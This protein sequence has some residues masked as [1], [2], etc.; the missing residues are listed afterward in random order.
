MPSRLFEG[1][2][3][4]A[5]LRR[6]EQLLSALSGVAWEA[7]PDSGTFLYVSDHA[8]RILGFP[9]GEWQQPG[10][11][12]AH[13][14]PDDRDTAVAARRTAMRARQ[15]HELDYRMVGASGA[16]AWLRDI[17][18][19]TVEPGG[20]VRLRGLIVDVTTQKR[21]ERALRRATEELVRAQ[22]LAQIRSFAHD[23][24]TGQLDGEPA[25]PASFDA[26]LRHVHPADAVHLRAHLESTFASD[27]SDFCAEYR[28]LPP[29]GPM[30]HVA[31]VGHVVR[32][33]QRRAVRVFGTTQDVTKQRADEAASREH[34]H[35]LESLD[36]V[37]RALQGATS[38][39]QAMDDVLDAMLTMFDCDR[40]WVVRRTAAAA[41]EWRVA[42]ERTRPEHPG[43]GPGHVFAPGADATLAAT[44]AA[45]GR[46]R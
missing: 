15:D 8:E 4:D 33:A 46:S 23:I 17:A 1:L 31:A 30:R 42:F 3:G 9:A 10:F 18:S 13:L 41:P 38:L 36:V 43:A 34:V 2:T 24:T 44:A 11:W 45:G 22:Q 35:F 28:Y 37:N 32:D 27:A 12:A 7:D 39:E 14:H 5:A 25:A 20:E 16:V 26:F 6:A 29:D 40:A 19:I 21:T